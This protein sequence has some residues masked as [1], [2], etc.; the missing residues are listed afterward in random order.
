MPQRKK[1]SKD[2]PTASRKLKRGQDIEL[3]HL[4]SDDCEPE[5]SQVVVSL[6]SDRWPRD[7]CVL[8]IIVLGTYAIISAVL[9]PSRVA[10]AQQ[11]DIVDS[12]GQ[13]PATGALLPAKSGGGSH[14][15]K[16]KLWK[17]FIEQNMPLYSPPPP[18]LP[19]PLPPPPPGPHPPVPPSP[20]PPSAPSPPPLPPCPPAAPPNWP[21]FPRPVVAGLNA[22]FANGRPS[23]DLNLA[24]VII[25]QFDGQ[26]QDGAEWLPCAPPK[27]CAPFGDRWASS[28]IYSGHAG[29]YKAGINPDEG[30]NVPESK[31][32]LP[33]GIIFRPTLNRVLFRS[34]LL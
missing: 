23:N 31:R 34:H 27:W 29:L 20:P 10:A 13:Q 14:E 21:P 26:E 2:A 30:P 1:H 32:T 7:A 22:R 33:A 4:Q 8:M 11:P 9:A 28:L 12:V 5:Y 25:H 16:K 24:G 3:A 15:H 6:S 17:T 18:P 19:P